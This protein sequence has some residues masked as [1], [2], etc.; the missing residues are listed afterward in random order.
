MHKGASPA[1]KGGSYRTEPYPVGLT[2]LFGIEINE[3]RARP[4]WKYA[5]D[6]VELRGAGVVSLLDKGAFAGSPEI[7]E[8]KYGA[9]RA[10]YVASLP[11]SKDEMEHI[12]GLVELSRGK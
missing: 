1:P 12:L 4:D 10:F 11:T 2:D 3:Q 6:R 7:T 8:M 9:G 5:Y